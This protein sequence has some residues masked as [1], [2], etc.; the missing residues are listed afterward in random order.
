MRSG[1][2]FTGVSVVVALLIA[3]VGGSM[4]AAPGR[5][6][7]WTGVGVAFAGQVGIFWLLFV[8]VFPTRR[9]LAHMVGMM[10]RLLVFALTALVWVPRSGLPP[11]PTLFALVSFFFVTTLVE[12][13]FV[14]PR[15][16]SRR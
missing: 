11:A 12:S 9:I 14:Q 5:E 16:T 1:L 2:S 13:L 4:V 7:V 3:L 10:G 15:E 8:G 6:G